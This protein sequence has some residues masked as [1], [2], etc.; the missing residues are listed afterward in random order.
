MLKVKGENVA[1]EVIKYIRKDMAN[2][3]V[4]SGFVDFI[5]E[6]S[7]HKDSEKFKYDGKSY[8]GYF[9]FLYFNVS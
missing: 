6:V 3:K 1:E 7:L 4:K 9:W 2:K 5:E 8:E